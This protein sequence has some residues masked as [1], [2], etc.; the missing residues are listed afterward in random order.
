MFTNPHKKESNLNTES[1]PGDGGCLNGINT[2]RLE[3]DTGVYNL[4]RTN[5]ASLSFKSA[6]LK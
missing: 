4:F 6:R 1:D 2:H 5:K 3:T